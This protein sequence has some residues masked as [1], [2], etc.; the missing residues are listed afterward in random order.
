MS[1]ET[2]WLW[3]TQWVRTTWS[4]I[5]ISVWLQREYERQAEEYKKQ[6][7]CTSNIETKMTRSHSYRQH[8]D[9]EWHRAEYTYQCDCSV[10]MSDKQQNTRSRTQEVEYKKQNTRSKTQEAE[11]KKQNIRSRIQEAEHKKQNTRSRTQEVKHTY[12]WHCD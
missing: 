3:T 12:E 11:C 9:Y 6:N 7:I 4:R 1:D 8:S 5:H 2:S 10:S